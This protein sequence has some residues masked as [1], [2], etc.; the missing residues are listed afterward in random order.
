MYSKQ[1]NRQYHTP[2]YTGKRALNDAIFAEALPAQ[3]TAA[4]DDWLPWASVARLQQALHSGELTSHLLALYCLGR[5]RRCAPLNAVGEL[6]PEALELA[7]KLD[8]ERR[9]GVLRGPLHGIPL[10][11]KDNISTGDQ[12]HVTA[13]AKVLEGFR[14]GADSALAQKLRAA[15]ALILGK[16]NLSE[17]ANFMTSTSANGFSVLGGQVR[18]PYGKYDVSGSSSGSAAA[19]AAGL[20]PL[21]VGT[22]TCGSLIAPGSANSI[23][24][25]KPT[26]GLVSRR[27]IIPITGATDTAGPMARSVADLA[28]LLQAMTGPDPD[29][30]VTLQPGAMRAVDWSS[31]LDADALRGMRLGFVTHLKPRPG[32]WELI[33]RCARVLRACGAEVVHLST[34][35]AVPWKQAMQVFCYGMQHDLAGYFR[36]MPGPAPVSS[37]AEII[38]FNSA[39]L[40]NRAPFGQ[41]LLER[42]Q[43]LSITLAQHAAL[44]EK[45]RS[46]TGNE[47]RRLRADTPGAPEPASGFPKG[48]GAGQVDLLVSL[49]N[50]LSG[51]YA[52]AGFPALTVPAGYRKAGR[53]FGLTF[54]GEPFEDGRLIAAAYAFEQAAQAR[55]AP[56]IPHVLSL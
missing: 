49:G 15:G 50:S 30:P 4:L 36:S 54:V 3:Q 45:I 37:L 39:D 22:E 26:L 31:F 5:I 12:M 28:P 32:E 13:G 14:A 7:S 44:V 10:L 23:A 9:S 38:A 42:S 47:L 21:A 51:Y 27:G 19:V 55:V 56:P 43:A 40:P 53:P 24:V 41:D 16:A 6:N 48:K 17:W 35:R 33:E 20:V 25:L 8:D 34:Q 52:I 1:V 18:N 11:L 46:V 2:A 29:D